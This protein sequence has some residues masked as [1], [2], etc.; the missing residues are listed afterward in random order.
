MLRQVCRRSRL[1]AHLGRVRTHHRD[2]LARKLAFN[3]SS[4]SSAPQGAPVVPLAALSAGEEAVFNSKGVEMPRMDYL[5]V[6]AS[7]SSNS[8]SSTTG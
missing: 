5:L 8:R 1:E 4:S 7:S 2:E 6:L 3:L